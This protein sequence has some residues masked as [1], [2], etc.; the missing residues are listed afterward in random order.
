MDPEEHVEI[1]SDGVIEHCE[2][3][4]VDDALLASKLLQGACLLIHGIYGSPLHNDHLEDSYTDQIKFGPIEPF[5][6]DLRNVLKRLKF[7]GKALSQDGMFSLCMAIT[8][9]IYVLRDYSLGSKGDDSSRDDDLGPQASK[10]TSAFQ[11]DTLFGIME[12]AG[13]GRRDCSS[14]LFKDRLRCWNLSDQD[15]AVA[16]GTAAHEM[17]VLAKQYTGL[18]RMEICL[19]WNL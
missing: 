7:A 16:E 15:G 12:R 14:D 17:W 2:S 11:D 5:V 4:A 13:S 3:S 19:F 1:L 18:T 10:L 8:K 9:I 6:S